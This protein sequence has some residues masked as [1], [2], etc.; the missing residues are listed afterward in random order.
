MIDLSKLS[1]LMGAVMILLDGAGLLKPATMRALIKAFPR[2][3][4]AAWILTTIDLIWAGIL[5]NQAPLGRFDSFKPFLYVLVPVAILLVG[6]FVDELL[7]PRALGG[8][9]LLIAT[10]ILDIARWH[11]SPARLI[12]TVLAYL[13]VIK[14]LVLVIAPYKVRLTSERFLNTDAR[15]RLACGAGTLIGAILIGLGFFVY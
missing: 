13:I 1:I 7:A 2:N 11:D 6:F 14:G 4:P 5:L 8:L 3:R 15:C 12:V 10:P 9:F